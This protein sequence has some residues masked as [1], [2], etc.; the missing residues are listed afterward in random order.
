MVRKIESV[1]N[2]VNGKQQKKR[3][4]LVILYKKLKSVLQ[5]I[6]KTYEIIFIDDGSTDKSYAELKRIYDKD[7]TVKIIK[8]RKNCIQ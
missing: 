4:L 2:Y 6:H 1:Q 8:F 3:Q 5:G 7:K